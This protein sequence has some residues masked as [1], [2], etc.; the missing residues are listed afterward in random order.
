MTASRIRGL[1]L[2]A[3]ALAGALVFLAWSQP[4]YALTLVAAAGADDPVLTVGGD[5][6]AAGLAALALTTLAVV[7][8]LAI[9]GPVFRRILGVLEAL[10][11][12]AIIGLALVTIGD[13]VAASAPAITDATGISGSESVAALV[14]SVEGTLWPWM[15]VV[16]GALIIVIGVVVVLTAGRWPVT[17]RKYTRTRLEPADGTTADAVAEW[18]ALSDGD[19]PTAPAR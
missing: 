13:P 15:A 9:A 17:G 4:W 7:A 19:D 16:F 12:V 11:G 1:L 6:A 3:T 2:G 5:I 18:D 8:A 10:V 14:S